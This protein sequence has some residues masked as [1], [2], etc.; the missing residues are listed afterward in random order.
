MTSLCWLQGEITP[1]NNQ[2]LVHIIYA[3]I[4]FKDVLITTNK[5][6]FTPLT[7]RG[8]VEECFI[9]FEYVGIDNAGRRVM[10]LVEKK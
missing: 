1:D 8:R 7:S 9:G 10:G 3:S 5:I 2:D 6:A 4:N